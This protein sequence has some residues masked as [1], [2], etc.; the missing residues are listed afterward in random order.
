[1][2]TKATTIRVIQ[3]RTEYTDSEGRLRGWNKKF[4]KPTIAADHWARQRVH[5]WENR[6]FNVAEL[7]AAYHRMTPLDWQ[8]REEREKK[9]YRRS[10]PIFK[11]MI[12]GG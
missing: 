12:S 3:L 8:H 7:G 2:K 1:M 5:E 10:L 9:L 4:Q 6:K 11:R